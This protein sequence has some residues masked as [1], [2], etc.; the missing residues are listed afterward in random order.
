MFNSTLSKL[1]GKQ[2]LQNDRYKGHAAR[3]SWTFERLGG[4]WTFVIVVG[5][6]FLSLRPRLD[7]WLEDVKVT[8]KLHNH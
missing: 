3:S 6:I 4:F 1:V 5:K 8:E 7:R 2:I